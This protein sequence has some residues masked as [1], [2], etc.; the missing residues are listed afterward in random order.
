M[1]SKS[2]HSTEELLRWDYGGE[3]VKCVASTHSTENAYDK[4]CMP[5]AKENHQWDLG[6]ERVQDI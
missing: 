5:D 2:N 3:K 6:S 1:C 4:N